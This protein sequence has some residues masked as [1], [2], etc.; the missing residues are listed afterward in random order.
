[1]ARRTVVVFF[2]QFF[3]CSAFAAD[4]NGITWIEYPSSG[5]VLGQGYN[6][7]TDNPATGTCVDFRPIQDASQETSYRFEEV[8]SKTQTMSKLDISAS[9]SLKMAVLNATA[10]LNFLTKESYDVETKKFLL[11]VDVTNSALFASP[12]F[13]YKL[14]SKNLVPFVGPNNMADA[15]AGDTAGSTPSSSSPPGSPPPAAGAPPQTAIEW[16]PNPKNHPSDIERCGHGFVAAIVSGASVQAFMTWSNEDAKS[17]TDIQGSLEADIGGIFSVKGSIRAV[18]EH[19]TTVNKSK[20]SVFKSGGAGSQL[21]V[22]YDTLK[23]SLLGLPREALSSPKPL[24]IGIL[25]Y[26]ALS[27]LNAIDDVNALYF[28]KMVSAFFL[29]TDV[30]DKT[31]SI[32]ENQFTVK[33]LDRQ[34]YKAP[35]AIFPFQKYL[36]TNSAALKLASDLSTLLTV[37]RENA[38]KR[39]GQPIADPAR[40]AWQQAFRNQEASRF[41]P[42]LVASTPAKPL[43]ELFQDDIAA[44][45]SANLATAGDATKNCGPE[46]Q[47]FASAIPEAINLTAKEIAERPIFFDDLSS[48]VQKELVVIKQD[49]DKATAAAT[50]PAAAEDARKKLFERLTTLL[51]AHKDV[52]ISSALF[53]GLCARSIDN[54]ICQYGQP[55]FMTQTRQLVDYQNLSF[56]ALENIKAGSP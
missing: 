5:V 34:N 29:A 8:I 47:A 21:A 2:V 13:D 30:F 45:R 37:C 19:N 23:T 52:N 16:N 20:I 1:M 42:L 24:R 48:S 56:A 49:Y 27:K 10:S 41:S 53:R 7:L 22:N 6:L 35:F 25:P 11:T 14:G 44:V 4:R 36:E 55:Q 43:R 28:Q 9:G 38:V 33:G 12:S 26:T 50:T 18:Q 40:Q 17:L 32:I 51:N 46:G 54:P 39:S 3:F 31:S 15:G